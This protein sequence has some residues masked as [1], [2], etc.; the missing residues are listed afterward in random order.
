MHLG[1]FHVWA[2]VLVQQPA[3]GESVLSGVLH[4]GGGQ[5]IFVFWG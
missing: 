3:A 5:H 4:V 2:E 1:N